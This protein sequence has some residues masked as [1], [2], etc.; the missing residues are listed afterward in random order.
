MVYG[1][2]F[3]LAAFFAVDSFEKRGGAAFVRGRLFRLGIPLLVYMFIIYPF[4]EYYLVKYNTIRSFPAFFSNYINHITSFL[5]LTSTRTIWFVE[6]LLL[7]SIIYAVL[8]SLRQGKANPHQYRFKNIHW[9]AAAFFAGVPLSI[10]II[11]AGGGVFIKGGLHWRSFAYAAWESF[12]CVSF[13][14]GILVFFKKHLNREGKIS[15]MIVRN[16]FG[17]YIFHAPIMVYWAVL[18]RNWQ[19]VLMIKFLILAVIT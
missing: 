19:M 15:R 14:L 13:S 16:T 18:L 9:L 8:R 11:P 10:I 12:F 17:I 1:V 7:F 6:V 3:F 5:W 4:I 2:L